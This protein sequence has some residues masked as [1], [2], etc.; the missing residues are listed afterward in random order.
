VVTR[1]LRSAAALLLLLASCST[2]RL[3]DTWRDPGYV[4]KPVKRVFVIGVLVR[5]EVFDSSFEK[6]MAQALTAKGYQVVTAS[7][8]FSPWE[9][10]S[11]KIEKYVRAHRMD[12]VVQMRI[13][14]RTTSS[15]TPPATAYVGMPTNVPVGWYGGGYGGYYAPGMLVTQQ[16]HVSE[17]SRIAAEIKVFSVP[18]EALVWSSSASV[19]NVVG[20]KDAGRSLSAEVVHDLLRAGILV[21]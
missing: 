1:K 7:M 17:D 19:E 9:L 21:P 2:T 16:G 18:G 15:Y 10:D 20:D 11:D 6:A 3:T 4:S 8:A 5:D 14:T 13:S 12:L